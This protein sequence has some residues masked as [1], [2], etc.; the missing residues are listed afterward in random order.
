M[1]RRAFLTASGTKKKSITRAV[2]TGRTSSGIEPYTGAWT[3]NEV[4]HLLKR[5]M[6][7]AKP[8]DIHYFAGKTME[9]AV[10]EL[11]NITSPLPDPPV[12]EYDTAEALVPDSNVDHGT[13]W[14]NDFNE[15]DK[16]GGL[17]KQSFK[18][19][20]VGVM[21]N[22]PRNIREK[23]MLF[24]HNHFATEMASSTN[25]RYAYKHHTLLR[26]H[27]LGNFKSLA[28]AIS[29]D[30]LML[31]YQNGEQNRKGAPDENFAREL[32]E[33]FTLGKE[34]NPNYTEDDVKA[35]ARVLTGWRNDAETNT[36][37]FDP[38]RHDT[39]NKTFSSFYNHTTIAGRSGNNAG[40]EELDDLINMIFSNGREASEYIVRELYRWFVYYEIDDAAKANVIE[41]LALMLRNYNWE[42]KPVLA[43]LLKSEHFF[44]PLNQGC[45]IKSPV[46]F[47]VGLCRECEVPLP[48]SADYITWYSTLDGLLYQLELLQQS[49]GDP[50]SVSGW[51]AYYQIPAFHELWIN[52][53]TYP[54]RTQFTDIM[55]YNGF[56]RLG[57]ELKIDTIAFARSLSNPGDPKVLLDDSLAIL[58][59][60]AL[61]DAAKEQLKRD[62][63]LTGQTND[64]YWTNAWNTYIANPGDMMA[65]QT[66]HARLNELYRYLLALPEYQLS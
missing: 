58:Y 3:G 39:G 40:D 16:I 62:L 21:L 41:P 11:L 9:A 54:R 22:Q 45:L 7:G 52:N 12:K 36:S 5:T 10:D 30:P 32:Q 17:R 64:Y 66:V 61:S 20:W 60:I 59:R 65:Y 28:R 51:P 27:A 18:K 56:T 14:I 6:F 34:N 15:D 43:A 47:V 31:V 2:V 13:T 42:I 49:P 35:A 50:P 1:N 46:D 26:T 55:V 57:F 25:A 37:Y 38:E 48:D 63:L 53:D 33:L 29:V 8:G 4:I 24:W 44:D 23:M 19:W